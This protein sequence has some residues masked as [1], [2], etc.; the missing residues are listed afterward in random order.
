MGKAQAW[1]R[2]KIVCDYAAAPPNDHKWEWS[3]GGKGA[4]RPGG[5]LPWRGHYA[6]DMSILLRLPTVAL[7]LRSTRAGA[8]T[9]E[10]HA[11]A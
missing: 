9:A 1:L 3:F 8:P 5:H 6:V 4:E 11:L 10:A 2:R 7:L